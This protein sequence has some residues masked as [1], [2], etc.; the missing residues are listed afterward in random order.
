MA[1]D[2]V[3]ELFAKIGLDDKEY[4]EKLTGAGGKLKTFGTKAVAAAGKAAKAV[5]VAVVTTTAAAT[6]ALIKG[7]SEVADY[8]DNIDKMSQKM[9][10]SSQ[11]Y[12]EWDAVMQHCGTSMESMQGAMKTLASAAE[13]DS[14]AFQKLGISQEEI[15]KMSEEELFEATIKAL[16]G[17]ESETER[18][19]LATKLLG[20]GGSELGPLLNMTAEETQA[21]RDRVHELGGVMSDEAVKAAA[22]YKDSLQDMKTSLGGLKRGLF[23]EFLPGI[24]TVMD[25]LTELFSGNGDKGIALIQKGLEN[26]TEK[27]ETVVPKFIDVGAKI[28]QVLTKAI[29]QNLPALIKTGTTLLI[30][31]ITGLIQALP[32]LIRAIPDIIAAIVQGFK[33]NWPAIKQAGIDLVKALAEGF[34]S[35]VQPLLDKIKGFWDDVKSA[36]R[37]KWDEITQAVGEKTEA[38]R[39]YLQGKWDKIK[40]AYEKHG[41][42]LKGAAAAAMEGIKQYYSVGWDAI[43]TLTGGKLD[44]M[45]DKIK[46]TFE[47]AKEIVKNAVERLKN[48]VKF[49]WSLPKLKL[50]H[51]SITGHFSIRPPS[52]PHFSI[53]WYKKAYENPFLFTQPTV[54]QGFGDG[55]GSEIVYG[56]RNLMQDIEEA[57]GRATGRTGSGLPEINITALVELDGATLARKTYKYSQAE[58]N[59]HGMS[60]V[61]A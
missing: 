8:G 21:M 33:E 11:A 30:A 46:N 35:M 28:L 40:A 61:T 16:Q 50:P 14:E 36:T 47:R 3:Y 1:N 41:G 23:S 38:M 54:L 17:V 4:D 37:K 12:Q 48:L 29:I 10:M 34:L 5:G 22:K 39:T 44:A 59:R 55:P 25:G 51:I 18:T 43:N 20:R 27:A 26:I 19:Y 32:D 31:V 52:A 7:A 9:N 58:S 15:A 45:R 24:T 60:L 2:Y 53:E 13:T 49:D 6:A 56:H 42:G 57:V